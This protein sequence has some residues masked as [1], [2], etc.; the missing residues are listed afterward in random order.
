LATVALLKTRLDEGKDHLGLFGP[1]VDDTVAHFS[2]DHFTAADIRSAVD[3]RHH[4]LIPVETINTLLERLG[5]RGGVRREGG[6]YFRLPFKL[7]VD[8]EAER[9]AVE[10]DLERLGGALVTFAGARKLSVT[11]SNDALALLIVFLQ[12]NNVALLLQEPGGP[13]AARRLSTWLR[14]ANPD[15]VKTRLNG[16]DYWLRYRYTVA[17][18]LDSVTPTGATFS[19]RKYPANRTCR[20]SESTLGSRR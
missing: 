7:G 13:F 17:G 5:R 14:T 16:R 3:E 11:T 19:S 2:E 9:A 6:R 18:L 8:I 12:E 1:F 20:M 4:L 15:S 10:A